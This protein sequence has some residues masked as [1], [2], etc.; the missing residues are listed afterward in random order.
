MPYLWYIICAIVDQVAENKI[1]WEFICSY[2][3]NFELAIF[4][5]D[6]ANSGNILWQDRH[7]SIYAALV[8][9]VTK[10]SNCDTHYMLK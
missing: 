10:G 9:F 7:Q 1:D 4:I 5:C 8:L 2:T 3:S 6:V